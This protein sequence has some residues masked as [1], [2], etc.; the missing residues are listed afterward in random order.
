M[1]TNIYIDVDGVLNA[2]PYDE[3]H[4]E[5]WPR[6]SWREEK[7]NNF[8]ITWSVDLVAALNDI[9]ARED[10]TFKWLT[11]WC[12]LAQE[13]IAPGLQLVGAEKWAVTDDTRSGEAVWQNSFNSEWWKLRA[14]KRDLEVN[15]EPDKIVWIDDDHGY[16]G[17]YRS[18]WAIERTQNE[19]LLVVQP[20]TSLGLTPAHIEDILEF[21]EN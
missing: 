2:L 15:G 16:Y 12:E 14:L 11:T 8:P 13:H 3:E 20:R 17:T 10:V 5:V 18:N 6:E 21:I 4:F 7:L 9:A 1:T 19:Q